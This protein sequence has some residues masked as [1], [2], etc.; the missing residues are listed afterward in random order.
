[1]SN[2]LYL[3]VT[4]EIVAKIQN[5]DIQ[6]WESPYGKIGVACNHTTGKPYQGINFLRLN[7]FSKKFPRYIGAGELIKRGISFAGCK[8]EPVFFYS[9]LY[10]NGKS[11]IDVETYQR[12]KQQGVKDLRE[13]FF[14]KKSNVFSIG[15]IPAFAEEVAALR[16]GKDNNPIEAAEAVIKGFKDCPPIVN[17][18]S[19]VAFYSPSR[20]IINMPKLEE[21]TSSEAYYSTF[22][23][24]AAH[25]TGHASRLNR[26]GV[27]NNSGFGSESYSFEELVAELTAAFIS[28]Q[29]GMNN[30]DNSAAYLKGWLKPLQSDV[31]MIFKASTAA[32]KAAQY[33][34]GTQE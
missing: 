3:E 11:K 8:A 20:D 32:T 21:M 26:E 24:E 12:L 17:E 14:L 23:H 2:N 19:R 34:T 4:N 31:N 22:F 6:K 15:D 25:S 7:F 1:M 13:S 30:M 16:E 33:I 9:P 29:I 27:T 28:A 18:D 5:G 10:F